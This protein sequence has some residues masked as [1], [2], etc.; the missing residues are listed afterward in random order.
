MVRKYPCSSRSH[1]ETG[2]GYSDDVVSAL[3][4]DHDQRGQTAGQKWLQDRHRNT[5]G[6]WT[7]LNWGAV[8]RPA[9][10]GCVVRSISSVSKKRLGSRVADEGAGIKSCHPT[11][12]ALHALKWNQ[13]C[14]FFLLIPNGLPSA[15]AIKA[16]PASSTARWIAVRLLAMGV[17]FPLSKSFTVLNPTLARS[18]KSFWDQ[19]NHPRAARLCSGDM[20]SYGACQ[21]IL[22]RETKLVDIR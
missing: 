9:V 10:I 5:R 6:I 16:I 8:R 2:Q 12:I 13:R 7:K 11:N 18:A 17:R 19:P 15:S 14:P 3:D 4:I 20:H 21:I 1:R 22:S